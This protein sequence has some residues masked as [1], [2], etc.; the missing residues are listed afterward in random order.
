MKSVYIVREDIV[1][2]IRIKTDIMNEYHKFNM[3][4]ASSS[5]RS[6]AVRFC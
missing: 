6:D 1:G 4:V 5:H 2:E 3:Q